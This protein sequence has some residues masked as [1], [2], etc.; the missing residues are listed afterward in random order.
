[1]YVGGHLAPKRLWEWPESKPFLD[2][3]LCCLFLLP[4]LSFQEI[5]SQSPLPALKA[6]SPT[7]PD[8]LDKIPVALLSG[9]YTVEPALPG[10]LQV[11]CLASGPCEAGLRG[12]PDPTLPFLLGS[13]VGGLVSAYAL[14][15]GAQHAQSVGLN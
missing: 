6:S 2:S 14:C 7:H 15:P 12:Q 1:M 11:V 3:S 9:T 13:E 4:G 10:P 8:V 5:T